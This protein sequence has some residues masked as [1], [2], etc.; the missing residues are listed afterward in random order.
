MGLLDQSGLKYINVAST[1]DVLPQCE[2]GKITSCTCS[3]QDMSHFVLDSIRKGLKT[4]ASQANDANRDR[5]SMMS[6]LIC[7]SIY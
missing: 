3:D 1:D 4:I 2:V 5:A 6:G 7:Y